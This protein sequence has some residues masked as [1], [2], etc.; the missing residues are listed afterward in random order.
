[1]SDSWHVVHGT[2]RAENGHGEEVRPHSAILLFGVSDVVAANADDLARG[3]GES[4]GHR[5]RVL[6]VLLWGGGSVMGRRA[7]LS[8]AIFEQ[9]K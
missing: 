1:V 8:I 9:S 7:I 6:C 4:G 3:G 5:E 2:G